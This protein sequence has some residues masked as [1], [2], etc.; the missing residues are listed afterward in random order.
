MAALHAP[1]TS[2]ACSISSRIRK[3]AISA[4]RSA[5]RA[6]ST[7]GARPR[8][9]SISCWRA[10]SA[11]TGIASTRRRSGTGT[12]A[13]RSMLEIAGERRGP[14]ER[15][16][17]GPDLAAGERPQAVVPARAWQAAQSLG[18]WT[19]VGCTVAPGFE[20]PASSWRP[21][22]GAAEAIAGDRNVATSARP[23]L[24]SLAD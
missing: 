9:R 14:V 3:A 6:R 15:M 21:K 1:P 5:T 17:L 7:E 22:A 10:A 16:T 20:F 18:D 23:F 24:P 13:R 8:P 4:R 2:S 12:P 11:R 19:L